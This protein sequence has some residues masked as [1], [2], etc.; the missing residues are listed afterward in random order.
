MRTLLLGA[1]CLPLSA[2]ACTAFKIT[3]DGRTIVGNNE[4]AWSI[5]ARVRFEQGRDGGYGAVYF[6]HF[7]GSPFRTMSDQI[8]MNEAGLVFD[9]LS[10]QQRTDAPRSLPGKKYMSFDELMPLVMRTCATVEESAA[11][12]SA[13]T[14]AQLVHSMLF[15]VDRNGGYLIVE[16][17]TMMIGHDPTYAVG[18]WR[19]STCTDPNAIPIPRLQAGRAL[20]TSGS[21]GDP[22]HG[23]AVL[24]SMKACRKKLGEGTLFSTLFD[25][26]KG[27]VRLYFYHDYTHAVLFD[28]EQELAKGDREMTME[29]LFPD[30]AEFLRLKSFVTPFHARWL[31]WLMLAWSISAL[32]LAAF[33]VVWLLRDVVRIV[34]RHPHA[35]LLVPVLLGSSSGLAAGLFGVLLVMEG[36]YYSG[37][38]D[39]HPALAWIPA[40]LAV[41]VSGLVLLVLKNRA[42]RW[43]ATL[44]LAHHVPVLAALGYWGLLWP[45]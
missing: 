23:L 40:L 10:I 11:L 31:Y 39:V 27:L 41:L 43:A 34:R 4:D 15:L 28:L 17:D 13:Y 38:T 35:S 8:G 30:N 14:M 32:L 24:S 25:P 29:S 19:M 45:A 42:P 37:L 18:N 2:T 7:N 20:L 36:P 1:L 12:L 5:N 21:P 44:C 26:E 22:H 6:G 33:S 16:D 9:G 3:A